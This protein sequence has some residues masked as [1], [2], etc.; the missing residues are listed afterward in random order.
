MQFHYGGVYYLLAAACLLS[1]TVVLFDWR[2]QSP[3]TQPVPNPLSPY[4][5]LQPA[6]FH[7][8]GTWVNHC[9]E[10]PA[11]FLMFMSRN[12]RVLGG[13]IQIGF[14]VCGVAKS[15][16]SPRPLVVTS[17]LP[18]VILISS[19]NLS[20]LNHLTILPGIFCLDDD[21]WKY[22]FS[23]KVWAQ[24]TVMRVASPAPSARP[25]DPQ[26]YV[27]LSFLKR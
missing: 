3:E 23:Q 9:V 7:T 22:V 1:F 27:P 2:F 11:P 24:V 21:V 10:L 15:P 13:V 12:L 20:F 6:W 14:Q 18:Q 16:V 8:L 17:C 26:Q 4:F 25:L 19:G 5:H